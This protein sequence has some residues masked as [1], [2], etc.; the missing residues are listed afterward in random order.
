MKSLTAISLFCSRCASNARTSSSR[1]VKGSAR[2]WEVW[3]VEVGIRGL[4]PLRA[5]GSIYEPETVWATMAC[6]PACNPTA[7]KLTG[8]PP[9]RSG[10]IL[11]LGEKRPRREGGIR[12]EGTLDIGRLGKR[13]MGRAPPCMA[14]SVKSDRKKNFVVLY[15]LFF[16]DLLFIP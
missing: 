15:R 16:D 6:P 5:V 10:R 13:E 4:R 11:R 2:G 12:K 7:Y 3:N 8:W 1:L 14:E 9:A